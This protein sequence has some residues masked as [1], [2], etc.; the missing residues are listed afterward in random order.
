MAVNNGAKK[1]T[2][3]CQYQSFVEDLCLTEYAVWAKGHSKVHQHSFIASIIINFCWPIKVRIQH[4]TFVNLQRRNCDHQTV[5]Y[6]E[7]C[8]SEYF[9]KSM[10]CK[11]A[12]SHRRHN[13]PIL[14]RGKRSTHIVHS[15]VIRYISWAII[16]QPYTISSSRR[17]QKQV[18][19]AL[20][21]VRYASIHCLAPDQECWEIN[22]FYFLPIFRMH[23]CCHIS[24]IPI[25]LTLDCVC[26]CVW[27]F[28]VFF[29][30][31][32]V[33]VFASLTENA[34]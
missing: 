6:T 13:K 22:R 30:C 1:L 8:I 12:L 16:W 10:G 33:C 26:G 31:V 18:G 27:F 21:V 20:T 24:V 15:L 9:S 2:R 17:E 14:P 23:I 19:S 28:F 4:I 25:H 32:C 34:L 5:N 3:G 7:T 29:V 11:E